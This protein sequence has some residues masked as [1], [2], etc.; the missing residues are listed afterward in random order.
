[1]EALFAPWL[2]APTS[3]VHASHGATQFHMLGGCADSGRVPV[4][5]PQHFKESEKVAQVLTSLDVRCD[6]TRFAILATP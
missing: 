3:L 2:S 5:E 1:M 6:A 4:S